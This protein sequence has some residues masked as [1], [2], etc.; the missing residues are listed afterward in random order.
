MKKIYSSLRF[1]SL[2]GLGFIFSNCSNDDLGDSIPTFP[3]SQMSVI[4]GDS[5]KSWRITEVINKYADPADDFY[6]TLDCVSDDI[7]TFSAESDEAIITYG[8]QLCFAD[9]NDGI[10]TADREAFGARL[11][12]LDDPETIYMSFGRGYTNKDN[13]A[14][15]STF[16]Y[17]TLAELSENRMVFCRSRTGILGDYYEA[18]TFETVEDPGQE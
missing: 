13:T 12:M 9:V 2:I 17:Y 15:G 6:F 3:A 4:H 18:Y 14:S 16:A 8:D 7:Y 5:E 10:F 1:L 11:L